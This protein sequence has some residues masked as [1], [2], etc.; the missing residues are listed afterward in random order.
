MLIAAS[1]FAGVLSLIV[2]LYW[3]AVVRPEDGDHRRI[4]ERLR[5]KGVRL[6]VASLT[7]AVDR[8]PRGLA[9]PLALLLERAGSRSSVAAIVGLCLGA[10]AAAFAIAVVAFHSM[11]IALVIAVLAS[12]IPVLN[13]RRLAGKRL[14]IFEEQF[15]E[16]IDL[17]ARAL[18][19]GHTLSTSIQMVAEEVQDPIGAE[20]KLLFERQNFGMSLPDALKAFGDRIPLL[21]ARFFVTAVLTQRET[22]GNLSEVLDK[23]SAVIR[24]RFKVKRQVRVL[25]AHGRITGWILGALPIAVAIALYILSP[26]HIRLLVDD[27]LG[28]DMVIGAIVL[29]CIGVFFIRR[30]VDVEF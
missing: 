8:A 13:L 16:A 19:A 18:R 26:E 6:S 1:V 30:I 10:A 28:V 3:V 12:A 29:Q 24:E 11:L 21:D 20:F 7:K 9:A 14:K 25:S 22:G 5:G 17:M 23:L 2:G 15:P 4:R 27:P